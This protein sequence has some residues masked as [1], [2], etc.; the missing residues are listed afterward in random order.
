MLSG[1]EILQ[2]KLMSYKNKG[3]TYIRAYRNK[4]GGVRNLD[5]MILS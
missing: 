2:L 5:L 4:W 3:N 1:Q